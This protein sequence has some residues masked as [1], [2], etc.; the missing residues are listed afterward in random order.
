[1]PDFKFVQNLTVQALGPDRHELA[2]HAD[3]HEILQLDGLLGSRRIPWLSSTVTENGSPG[4]KGGAPVMPGPTITIVLPSRGSPT[5]SPGVAVNDS[6][7]PSRTLKL[8]PAGTPSSTLYPVF[9]AVM[10]SFNRMTSPCRQRH[11]DLGQWSAIATSPSPGVAVLW[12]L[13][14]TAAARMTSPPNRENTHGT[15]LQYGLPGTPTQNV[16]GF[17]C[18]QNRP[19]TP[20]GN[21]ISSNYDGHQI[22]RSGFHLSE[23]QDSSAVRQAGQH[24]GHGKNVP[25]HAGEA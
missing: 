12:V 15:R 5:Q 10:S 25:R 20:R 21:D 8:S 7:P 1:V 14:G 17:R 13:A 24:H 23:Q 22:R 4:H 19:A 9:E 3:L 16:L 18:A 6:R 2:F 11:E